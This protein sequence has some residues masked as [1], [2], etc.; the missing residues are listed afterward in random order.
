MTSYRITIAKS[1]RKELESL[2]APLIARIVKRMD[3]LATEPRRTGCRKL[4]GGGGLWRIRIA[5]YR[6]LYSVDDTALL[7]DIVAVRHRRDAYR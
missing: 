6:V 2:D 4:E 5:D 7:V 3:A 1:A